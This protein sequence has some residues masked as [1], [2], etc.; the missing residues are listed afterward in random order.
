MFH[1]IAPENNIL[2]LISWYVFFF[3]NTSC[4][5][6]TQRFYRRSLVELNGVEDEDTNLCGLNCFRVGPI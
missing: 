4:M 1:N 2:K 6:F 3:L 5:C